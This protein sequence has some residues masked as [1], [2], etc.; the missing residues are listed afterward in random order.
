MLTSCRSLRCAA[1]FKLLGVSPTANEKQIKVAFRTLAKTLHP[2][3]EGG[4]AEK[5]INVRD[6]YLKL[7]GKKKSIA[8]K[9]NNSTADLMEEI[10]KW[11]RSNPQKSQTP[12]NTPKSKNGKKGWK[13]DRSKFDFCGKVSSESLKC[14]LCEKHLTIPVA[15]QSS[16]SC[17]NR[18][19]VSCTR[20]ALGLN[21]IIKKRNSKGL[22]NCPTCSTEINP[23]LMPSESSYSVDVQFMEMLDRSLG[24]IPCER[25]GVWSGPRAEFAEHI[26]RCSGCP[27]CGANVRLQDLPYHKCGKPLRKALRR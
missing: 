18:Y 7:L 26:K 10:M 3:T 23:P 15:I 16:C 27:K 19:C 20:D 12:K 8:G 2:D 9:K 25:C 14:P 24:P 17:H 21:G 4:D 22:R 1:S 5:F 13:Q 6:A 11:Q